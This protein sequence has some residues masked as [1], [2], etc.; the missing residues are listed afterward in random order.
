MLRLLAMVRSGLRPW[1]WVAE[2]AWVKNGLLEEMTTRNLRGQGAGRP[3]HVDS[4]LN[5]PCM[6]IEELGRTQRQVSGV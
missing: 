3:I 5:S 4:E 2:A 6:V 1:S